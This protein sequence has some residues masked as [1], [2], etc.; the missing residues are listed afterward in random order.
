M[1]RFHCARF[2]SRAT[3]Q[4]SYKLTITYITHDRQGRS[5]PQANFWIAATRWRDLHTLNK[6]TRSY[7]TRTQSASKHRD[8]VNKPRPGCR[9][10]RWSRDIENSLLVYENQPTQCCDTQKTFHS[11]QTTTNRQEDITAIVATRVQH[12]YPDA[13]TVDA[14]QPGF[15]P[16]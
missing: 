11:P 14:V 15:L 5:F 16:T 4:A 3:S 9:P 13:L 1:S 6:E 12:E 2:W 8:H 10:R 7:E